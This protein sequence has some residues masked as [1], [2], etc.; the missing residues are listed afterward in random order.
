VSPET[1]NKVLRSSLV[2]PSAE[3]PVALLSSGQGSMRVQ[4]FP[5]ELT[6]IVVYYYKN[7]ESFPAWNYITIAGKPVYDPTS[8]VQSNFGPRV[9]GELVLKILEYLGINLREVELANYA[10][11]KDTQAQVKE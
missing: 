8:S 11:G 9:H 6:R 2:K 3:Y 5:E 4:V 1:I 7:P 10:M